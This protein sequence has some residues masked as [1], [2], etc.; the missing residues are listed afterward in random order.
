MQLFKRVSIQIILLCV[1]GSILRL[2]YGIIYTPWEQAPD[3]IAW[4]IIVQNGGFRYDNLVY[5]PH[6]GGTILVTVFSR[7]LS[8]FTNFNSLVISAVIFD[9]V[10]R[11]VQIF[12]VRKVFGK[13]LMVLF[14]IWTIFALPFM[15]P[16]GTLNFGLHA[17]SS[18]FPFLLLYL[19]WLN[20]EGRNY[21]IKVGLFLGV[22]FWFSYSNG[23]LIVAFII[24]Q[25]FYKKSVR[26]WGYAL[27]SFSAVMII[28]VLL[29]IFAN[30][31]FHIINYDIS[32]I[33][34]TE[35]TLDNLEV[36]KHLYQVWIDPLADASV[37]IQNSAYTID[38]LKYVW[39]VL[40]VAG[41]IAFLRGVYKKTYTKAALAV[42]LV[43]L[44]FLA[45]YAI[46]PFYYVDSNYGSY[47]DYRHLTY[48][49]P[50]LALMVLVGLSTV[51]FKMIWNIL[52]LSIGIYGTSI[53]FLQESLPGNSDKAAGWVLA[54]KFGHEPE[55]LYELLMLPDRNNDELIQGIGWGMSAALF[56][57]E[58]INEPAIRKQQLDKLFS[59][60]GQYPDVAQE[61]LVKGIYFAFDEGITPVLNSSLQDDITIRLN[62]AEY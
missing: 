7:F 21:Y 54:L 4:E 48:I 46:S 34:G 14:G 25:L 13:Q 55:Q 52:F 43:V 47:I 8:L 56:S 27:L 31:G 44:I 11:F 26:Q 5:Y 59:L 40:A 22:A 45:A 33:R 16:W 10:V 29:R 28:H 39:L 15:I 49:L 2:V 41:I 62:N 42:G 3:Q 51:K 18:V 1:L 24:F 37:A 38:S 36:W 9:F 6:E 23:V 61:H 19:L 17:L 32:S 60:L 50:L 30:P 35:F 57:I 53:L 20:K 12:I 58:N